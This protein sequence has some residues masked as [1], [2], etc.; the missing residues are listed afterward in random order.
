MANSIAEWLL[1]PKNKIASYE[2]NQPLQDLL[3]FHKIL[4]KD[5]EDRNL[6]I[7]DFW[8][9]SRGRPYLLLAIGYDAEG[10]KAITASYIIGTKP[11]TS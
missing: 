8:K 9:S 6:D 1:D 7:D 11:K 5:L 2:I 4:L 10:S 3:D